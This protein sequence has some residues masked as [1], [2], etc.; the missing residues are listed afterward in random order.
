MAESELDLTNLKEKLKS[1]IRY[2]RKREI[3][4]ILKKSLSNKTLSRE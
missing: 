4:G 2:E 1:L 3:F